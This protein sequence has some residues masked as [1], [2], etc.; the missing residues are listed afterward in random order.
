MSNVLMTRPD[1]VL[2]THQERHGTNNTML[3]L[4]DGRIL[5]AVDGWPCK[6]IAQIFPVCEPGLNRT[7][8][9]ALTWLTVG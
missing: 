7:R 8:R 5:R 6:S 3:D 1:L 2:A 9:I 4:G